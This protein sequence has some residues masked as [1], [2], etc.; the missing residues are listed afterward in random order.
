MA[1][2]EAQLGMILN[3]TESIELNFEMAGKPIV[4]LNH[5]SPDNGNTRTLTATGAVPVTTIF[6]NESKLVDDGTGVGIGT[7]DLRALSRVAIGDAVDMNGLKLQVMYFKNLNS[8][9][10]DLKIDVGATN[11][12]NFGATTSEISLKRGGELML[13]QNENAPNVTGTAK[14]IDLS[15]TS[16]PDLTYQVILLAG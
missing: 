16:D 5:S 2:T 11:G 12:Y 14:T 15:S 10:G 8:N 7:L 13:F 4:E 3:A 9:S 1:I 6:S